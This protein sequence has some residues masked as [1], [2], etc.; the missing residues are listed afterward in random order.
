LGGTTWPPPEKSG[1]YWSE[2]LRPLLVAGKFSWIKG[3]QAGYRDGFATIAPV[4]SYA[5][6]RFGLYDLGG[7]CVGVVRRLV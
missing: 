7:Q 1:N 2:E 5:A 4:G 3:E 6:N